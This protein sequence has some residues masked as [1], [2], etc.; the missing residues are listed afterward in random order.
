MRRRLDAE[1]VPGTISSLDPE[2]VPGTISR[3]RPHRVRM[4]FDSYGEIDSRLTTV[5]LAPLSP[6]SRLT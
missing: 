3:Q 6:F 1:M 2:M 4:T 5:S